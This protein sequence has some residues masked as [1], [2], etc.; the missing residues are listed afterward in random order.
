M[1]S[2]IY[3]K[4]TRKRCFEQCEKIYFSLI[5]RKYN[6]RCGQQVLGALENLNPA[7]GFRPRTLY[8][9]HLSKSKFFS[10]SVNQT[11]HNWC[12]VYSNK[13]TNVGFLM[14]CA[15]RLRVIDNK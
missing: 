11:V 12:K 7:A 3:I 8:M 13:S 10:V 6:H 14:R 1:R 2:F 9:N 15:K 4:H 5:R